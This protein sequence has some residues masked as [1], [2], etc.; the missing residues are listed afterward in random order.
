M[1]VELNRKENVKSSDNDVQTLRI[2]DCNLCGKAFSREEFVATHKEIFHEHVKLVVPRFVENG[3]ELIE[4][5]VKESTPKKKIKKSLQ[6]NSKRKK[7]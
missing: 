4:S 7:T 2:H 3:D 6:F 5:F 1:E